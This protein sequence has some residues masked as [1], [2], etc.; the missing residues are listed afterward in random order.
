MKNASS[1]TRDGLI[2]AFFAYFIWGVLPVYWKILG[3][4]PPLELIAWRVAGCGVLAWIIILFRSRLVLKA[5]LN[6]GLFFRI[7]IASFLIGINWMLFI[8]AVGSGRILEASLGYYINPLISVILGILFFSESLGK[9]R[10]TALLLALTGVII[11]TLATGTFPWVSII[12]AL[13][14]GLY[15]VVTKGFPSEIDSIELLAWEMVILS[16]LAIAYLAFLGL[17]GSWH[18]I[19]YGSTTTIMLGLAG[20]ITLGPLWL[21][22]IGAKRLP[23]GMLGFLQ[24]IAPTLMLFLGIFVYGEPFDIYKAS[25]FIF[26]MAAVWLY[27]STLRT[28]TAAKQ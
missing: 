24:Y 11:M 19:S 9:I 14:F 5:L 10:L 28:V 6:T 15:G 7:I 4:V 18:F 3:I 26:I 25:S 23:L 22:S 21:F 27:S 8:W 20:V 2:S 16:P 12:L 13:T 1:P 17:Q